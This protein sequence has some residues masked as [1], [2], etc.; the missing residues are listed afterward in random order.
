M[1]ERLRQLVEQT[2][3][4][5]VG[6]LT[7]SLGVASRPVSGQTAAEAMKKA[8]VLMYRAKQQGRNRVV[9]DAS[10]LPEASLR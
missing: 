1:G 10:P 2:E 7:I 4:K 8:D 3:I 9:V 6:H 5:S